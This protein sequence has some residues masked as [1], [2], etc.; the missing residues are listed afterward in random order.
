MGAPATAR[1]LVSVSQPS[2]MRQHVPI[3]HAELTPADK[4]TAQTRRLQ[5]LCCMVFKLHVTQLS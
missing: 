4:A 5:Y 1:S 2:F 3:L